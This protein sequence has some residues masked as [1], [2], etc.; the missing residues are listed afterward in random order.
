M[1]DSGKG[2]PPDPG[3]AV[4]RP[5]VRRSGPDILDRKDLDAAFEHA[6]D[7]GAPDRQAYLAALGKRNPRLRAQVVRLLGLS[8]RAIG[9]DDTLRA[10]C[11]DP[12]LRDFPGDDG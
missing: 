6:L 3:N 9:L 12:L 2:S 5:G 8:S 10:T 11:T 1:A 4:E 7:L